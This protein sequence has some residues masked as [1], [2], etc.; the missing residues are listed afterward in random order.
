VKD[1][2]ITAASA[3]DPSVQQKKIN[4]I[5]E[6]HQDIFTALTR[7]PPH[8]PVKRSY[9]KSIHALHVASSPT[10]SFHTQADH[11]TI[12]A[13]RIQP[14][15][16]QVHNNFHQ[17]KQGSFFSKKSSS[18]RFRFSKSFP[19]NLTQWR[20]LLPKGG[21]MIQE[22]IGGHPPIL[23]AQNRGFRLG[24]FSTTF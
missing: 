7:V 8:C 2:E 22:K 17:A 24:S 18:P 5:V 16:Q 9:N 4:K 20:P 23:L 12:S 3:Q 1:T 6:E 15:Q 13:E 14:L 19:R 10:N 21:R 11:A